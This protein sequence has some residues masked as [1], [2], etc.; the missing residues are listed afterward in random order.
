[1]TADNRKLK[2]VTVDVFTNE[3]FAGNPLAIV[4]IPKAVNLNQETKQKIA[5]EFNLSETVFL[6]ESTESSHD[7]ERRIDIFTVDSEL[8]F[9]G[10]PTIGSA[11]FISE[12]IANCADGS[13]AKP[14]LMG[15]L[16]T[17]AGKTKVEYDTV[18]RKATATIPHNVHVHRR[19]FS[20]TQ[21]LEAQSRS[22]SIASSEFPEL[23]DA[24][25]IVSIVRGMTFIL[26]QLSDLI[27]LEGVSPG[28]VS[29]S[30]DL[31][32]EWSQTFL[33][34]YFYV[35][36]SDSDDHIK[37]LR[38]RMISSLLEDPATGSAASALASYLSLEDGRKGQTHQFTITQGV[39][40]GRRSDIDVEV[41]L[42]EDSTIQEVKLGGTAK[43]ILEGTVAYRDALMLSNV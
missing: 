38:T 31:D 32:V 8:P 43:Q 29:V 16:N 35:D 20:K 1:M 13:K 18:E 2:F 28:P 25:P 22:A 33:G 37:R 17:K 42:A 21:L 6:H 40:M 3:R 9:A 41:T 34:L 39:E 14:L 30:A 15:T 27:T 10:H 23:P 19:T 36:V 7:W 5:R 24:S 26:I 4:E 11:C 12:S